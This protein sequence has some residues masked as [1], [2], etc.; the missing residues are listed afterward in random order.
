[1]AL[2]CPIFKKGDP[3]DFANYRPVR[4]TSV[5]CKVFGRILKVAILSFFS[6]CKAITGCKNG[7]LPR[8]SCPPN[9]SIKEEMKIQLMDDGNIA[10]VV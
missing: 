6:D 10:G 4:L 8:R 2:I 5:V 9:L 7:F 3:E 1:M